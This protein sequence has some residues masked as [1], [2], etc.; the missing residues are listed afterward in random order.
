MVVA[1]NL[2]LLLGLAVS[3]ATAYVVPPTGGRHN[4]NDTH[5]TSPSSPLSATGTTRQLVARD[6]DDPA[7]FSWIKKWAAIGDSFTAGIGSGSQQGALLTQD[8]KCSRY[9]YA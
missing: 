9:S 6:I 5:R 7:D 4:M 3:S 1:A 8:W 2:L